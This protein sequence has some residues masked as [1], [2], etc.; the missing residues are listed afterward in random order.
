[1]SAERVSRLR[2]FNATFRRQ[3]RGRSKDATA[4]IGLVVVALAILLYMLSQQAANLPSWLPGLGEE[5]VHY[6]AEFSSAQAV[7]P[8]QGQAVDI[9][10][11]QV[12]SI[13]SVELEDGVAV[14]G[15]DVEPEYSELI[16]EDAELLLRPKTNLND[17][18]VDVSPGPSA[19]PL[20]PGSTIP[21]SQ[22]QPN[23]NPDEFLATLDA[24]TRSY[25]QLL[26]GAG[27][28]GIYG[29]ST[30]LSRALR[31][32]GPFSRRIALLNTEVAKRRGAL[33]HVIH[34][35]R[36]LAE[37]LARND[38]YLR[39]FVDSSAEALGGF[40]DSSRS[41]EEALRELPST[42]KVARGALASSDALSTALR[43]TL[44]GLIPQAQA[45][46]S[47]LRATERLFDDTTAPIANQI[48]PFTRQIR[49]TVRHT[50]QFAPN[51]GDVVQR[52]GQGLGH[53]NYF[54]NQLAYDPPGDREPYLYYLPWLNHDLNATYLGQD[55]GGAL[56][57]SI[58]MLSCN[59]AF[60]ADGAVRTR[61]FLETLQQGANVANFEPD[62]ACIDEK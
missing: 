38:R 43:P 51:F 40:A 4:V 5:F 3:L 19:A 15:L 42:L 41:I 32:L 17:M 13:S 47:A 6:E 52:F 11:I 33:A 31:R 46:P 23:V 2:R 61:P 27:A 20:E 10:G 34:N 25:L 8:G 36:L 58:V 48:R 55:A 35:F 57:R 62:E 24:D 22:T 53:L 21:L 16:T 37:E 28:E 49:P 60:L 12:G 18:V 44:L 59:T 9:N 14:V 56:R 30:K 45:F 29:R 39:R 26:V 1:M 7:T 54:F 50:A